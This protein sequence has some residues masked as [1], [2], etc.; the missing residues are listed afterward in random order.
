MFAVVFVSNDINLPFVNLYAFL[1]VQRR[2]M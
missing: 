1:Q 2:S